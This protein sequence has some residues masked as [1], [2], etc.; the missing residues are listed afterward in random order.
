MITIFISK[1]YLLPTTDFSWNI[2]KQNNKTHTICCSLFEQVDEHQVGY[3][4]TKIKICLEYT[5]IYTG[6]LRSSE[7]VNSELMSFSSSIYNP[8][9]F[10][11]HPFGKISTT[12]VR[13]RSQEFWAK[14]MD[15]IYSHFIQHALINRRKEDII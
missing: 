13:N 11:L 6:Y 7:E 10:F 12:L 4:T 1:C 9:S 15:G 3:I 5:Y 14:L 8:K 2:Q